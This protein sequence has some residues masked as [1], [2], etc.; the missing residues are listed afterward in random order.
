MQIK[1]ADLWDQF[2]DE[3][4]VAE[5]VFRSFGGRNSFWGKAVCLRV[6]EDNVLV[7][8]ELET[9]GTG[10]V[11]VV[12]GGGSL[13]CALLGDI[14]AGLAISNRWNGVIIYGCIRDAM[15]ITAM[16]VGVKALNTSP[17]KSAKQGLG[18]RQ[19]SVAI[20]GVTIA[21]GDYV[22]ADTDGIL[23]ARQ[24]LLEA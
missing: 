2:E 5:P 22:Y 7:R 13:K 10:K 20:A 15:E 3:V 17:R 18:E 14:L 4:Q 21:P 6:L 1:T 23:V 12:D 9:D 8:R 24:N 11:L 16:P 19:V